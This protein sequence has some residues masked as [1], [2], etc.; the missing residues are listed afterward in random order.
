[1][2]RRGSVA[3]IAYHI[4]GENKADPAR[5]LLGWNSPLVEAMM[6]AR[7]GHVSSSAE[8]VRPSC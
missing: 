5:R 2:L 8:T 6:G 7:D 1:M 4:V 3:E